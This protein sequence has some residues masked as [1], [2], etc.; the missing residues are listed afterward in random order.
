MCGIAGI[1]NLQGDKCIQS[2]ALSKMV[3]C[4]HSRGPDDEGYVLFSGNDE[5]YSCFGDDTRFSASGQHAEIPGFPKQHIK[6]FFC[7]KT[8]VALGHRRLSIVDLSVKGHQPMATS[9]LRYWIV[10]N[11]EI[12]NFCEITEDLKKQGIRFRS[13]SDTEVI[14]HAY[15]T[16]GAA[17][18]ERFN[19]MFAFAIWDNQDKILFCARDRIG[20]KPFYYTIVNSQLLFASDIK[21]LI[22]SGMYKPEPDMEGLYLAMA[23]GIAPRPKTAF[24]NV[25]A[26]EQAHWMKVFVGSGRIKKQRYW[27]IPVG[28][29]KHSMT[30]AEAI[31]LLE[32]KLTTAIKYR[33][34]ADVPVGTFMSGGI[35]STTISAIASRLHPGI[36]A[37][38]LAYE[39]NAPEF[40]EVDQA[41]ATA[42]INPM[43]HIV[44]TVRPEDTLCYLDDWIAGYEE[45]FYHLAA[46]YVISKI[47]KD[48]NVIVILNGLGGDELFAG[49]GYYRW[50][51]RHSWIRYLSVCANM[52]GTRKLSHPNRKLARIFNL[53]NASTPDR[54]HTTLFVKT[55]DSEL[56]NLFAVDDLQGFNTVDYIH[57]LYVRDSTR[58][59]DAVEAM[60]Y[61]DMMNYIGNHHVHR[62]DQFTMAHSIEGRFPF[63]DHNLIEAAFTIP[64]RFKLKGN[65]QKYILRKVAAKYIAPQCLQ[66]EKK[67]FGLPL[68]QW[69]YGPLSQ[70]VVDKLSALKKRDLFNCNYI[71]DCIKKYE[72]RTCSASHTWH[73]VMLEL[74][75]ERFIESPYFAGNRR[76]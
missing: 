29:Q 69:L 34:V 51:A 52:F 45:P 67:G 50:A 31:E 16:W 40:D 28:T 43:E 3:A 73:L 68:K 64:S 4:M 48:N 60:S 42:S 56:H 18:L 23:F 63:L 38:T 20:I 33:L 7:R 71:T 39:S 19:G 26:L 46:N 59:E 2:V 21:T 76:R 41:R 6:N 62:V 12:Y 32:D 14:L 74:W 25:V 54:L 47:V 66:M 35:D 55:T 24:K 8:S 75:F 72:K 36:K 44:E 53:L 1:I 61:M 11:G 30:E 70:L 5:R 58:F 13:T 15:R 10:F 17:C 22:A 65:I 27:D 57:D 37:F 9:D 49:Y